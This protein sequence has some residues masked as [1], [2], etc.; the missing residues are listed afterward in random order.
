[1]EVLMLETIKMIKMA[2][3]VIRI[4]ILMAL[5]KLAMTLIPG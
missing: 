5:L 2:M 4:Q 3:T 1:M